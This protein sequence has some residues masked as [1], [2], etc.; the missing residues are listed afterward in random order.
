MESIDLGRLTYLG[1]LGAALLFWFLVQN[2]DSL[3][4]KFKQ[5]AAWVFIFIGVIAV[6]GLW[7]DIRQMA[8]PSL[9]SVTAEGQITVPRAPDGHYYL[10]L[11]VNGTPIEFLVDTGATEMVLTPKD[12]E[13]VGLIPASL[14]FWGRANTANGTVRTA[15]VTLDTVTVGPVRDTQ[16]SAYVNEGEMQ[17][18]L[19]GMAYLHRWDKL[20]ITPRGMVLSR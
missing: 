5:A 8:R 14:Q 17:Q 16:V 11:Q 9:A 10:T 4:T 18:S 6:F 15:P 7:E 19:L 12:A 3:G 20:E 2:R 1:I 13:R